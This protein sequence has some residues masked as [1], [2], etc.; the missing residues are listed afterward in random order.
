MVQCWSVGLLSE[1]SMSSDVSFSLKWQK[2]G[3]TQ[4]EVLRNRERTIAPCPSLTSTKIY[5]TKKLRTMCLSAYCLK[6]S[7]RLEIQILVCYKVSFNLSNETSFELVA[8][9]MAEKN[10]AKVD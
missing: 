7:R 6:S 2:K 8:S 5:S 1:R 9:A 10:N 3:S 4:K